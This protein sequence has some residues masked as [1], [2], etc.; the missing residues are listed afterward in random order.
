MQPWHEGIA[1]EP[2]LGLDRVQ[3]VGHQLLGFAGDPFVYW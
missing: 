2:G 1:G 3:L